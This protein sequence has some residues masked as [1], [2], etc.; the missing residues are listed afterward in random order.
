MPELFPRSAASLAT[1]TTEPVPAASIVGS[2]ARSTLNGPVRLMPMTR[3][4]TASLV[5]CAGEKSSL[6]PATFARASIRPSAAA[7]IASTSACAVMSAAHRDYPETGVARHEL[8]EPLRRDVDGD[9]AAT[10]PGDA[11]GG[12]PADAGSGTGHDDR[13]A[14]EASGRHPLGPA[15][16]LGLG[17]KYSVVR[18]EHQLV[19]HRLRHLPVADSD[20]LLQGESAQRGEHLLLRP[21]LLEQRAHERPALWVGEPLADRA[22]GGDGGCLGHGV[23]FSGRGDDGHSCTGADGG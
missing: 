7:T 8:V 1:L 20:E 12:R 14:G 19:D 2:T 18:G 11:G 13:A 23:L 5:S 16:G 15:G 6:M 9:D 17:G 3:S 10:L 22:A 21:A 4:Q